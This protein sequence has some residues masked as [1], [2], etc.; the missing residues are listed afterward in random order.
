MVKGKSR[1]AVSPFDPYIPTEEQKKHSDFLLDV[2]DTCEERGITISVFGGYGLDG[3][4]GN[5]TRDHGDFDF[6]VM[7]EHEDEFV[8]YVEGLGFERVTTDGKQHEYRHKERG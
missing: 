6:G 1:G 2:C 5:V 4:Y 3:L 8:K 7:E